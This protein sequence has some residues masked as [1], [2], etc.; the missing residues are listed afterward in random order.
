[1]IGLTFLEH[2][3]HP[4]LFVAVILFLHL[5][6]KKFWEGRKEAYSVSNR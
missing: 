2:I 4:G 5:H 6:F 1:M 3:L